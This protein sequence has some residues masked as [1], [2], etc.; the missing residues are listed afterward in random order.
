MDI[1]PLLQSA[2]LAFR[3]RVLTCLGISLFAAI[4]LAA[5]PWVSG[6]QLIVFVSLG[7]A[8]GLAWEES[9]GP[10][11]KSSTR[12]SPPEPTAATTA[13][14]AALIG[15]GGWGA[16]SSSEWGSMLF[17]AGVAATALACWYVVHTKRRGSM[18]AP[19]LLALVA[20]SAVGY[21]VGIVV[22]RNVG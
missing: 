21:V 15:F 17:G 16:V 7:V 1:E 19:M 8:L 3:W 12:P 14:A 18:Q 10:S 2:Y 4:K 20:A 6:P 22:A 5:L 11:K 9:W 13:V